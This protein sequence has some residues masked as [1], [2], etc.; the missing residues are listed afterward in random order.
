MLRSNVSYAAL[1]NN[2]VTMVGCQGTETVPVAAIA[3]D[4]MLAAAQTITVRCRTRMKCMLEYVPWD[5]MRCW[6]R[7]LALQG[8][9]SVAW[10]TRRWMNTLA[11]NLRFLQFRQRHITHPSHQIMITVGG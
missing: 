8:Q 3:D 9:T 4:T 6:S 5:G 11:E 10:D 2:S 7:L 1:L